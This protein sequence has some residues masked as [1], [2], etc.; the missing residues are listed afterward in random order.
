MTTKKEKPLLLWGGRGF[1]VRLI[2]DWILKGGAPSSART[3][4]REQKLFQ[5]ERWV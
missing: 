4:W 5:A 2:T 3:E 1:T